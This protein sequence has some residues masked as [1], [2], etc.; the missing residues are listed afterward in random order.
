MTRD[1]EIA[2][3]AGRRPIYL[4]ALRAVQKAFRDLEPL[5]PPPTETNA[6]GRPVMRYTE[7]LIEQAILLKFA[8]LISLLG[9]LDLLIE[10]GL[11]QEQGVLQRAIDETNEDI[12]FLAIATTNGPR[13]AL[14]ETYLDQFWQEDYGDASQPVATRIPRGQIKRSKI[15]AFLNRAFDQPDPSSA[16][17]V[18]ALLHGAYSG[19]VHGAAPHLM[20][21]FDENSGR[22]MLSGISRNIR[23]ID[24][25]LDAQNMFYRGLMSGIF[26]SKALGSE[27]TVANLT[28]AL[29]QFQSSI[30][31]AELEK[32]AAP[33]K[34]GSAP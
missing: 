21:L 30:G 27:M 18:G 32:P 6:T 7:H 5:L 19:F 4:A 3:A 10:Y 17:A 11:V 25:V 15:R 29:E 9:A 33:I 28:S 31:I 22:F 2:A 20:E 34:G 12:L 23:H 8:R 26:V 1:E 24:Y 13:T 14:H 16:D